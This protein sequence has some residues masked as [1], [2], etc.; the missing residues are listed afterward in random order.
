[1]TRERRRVHD[2]AVLVAAAAAEFAIEAF[3]GLRERAGR[4]AVIQPG[5]ISVGLHD[6]HSANHRRMVRAAK[7]GAV[8]MKRPQL[9]RLE[10]KRRV[11]SRNDILLD[12]KFR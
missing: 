7:F 4:F 8:K 6:N 1:E 11:T 12:A 5:F 10:P 9:V 3:A 2:G